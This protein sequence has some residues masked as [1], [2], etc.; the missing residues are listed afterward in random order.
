MQEIEQLRNRRIQ[1]VNNYRQ[2]K[3][4]LETLA[5]IISQITERENE[6]GVVY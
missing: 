3:I 6:L 5:T 2:G 4:D 1:S